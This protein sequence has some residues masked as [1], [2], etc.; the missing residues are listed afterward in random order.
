VIFRPC[1]RR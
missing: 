1:S